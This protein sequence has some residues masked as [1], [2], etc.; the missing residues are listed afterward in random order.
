MN[1]DKPRRPQFG[2]ASLLH[3]TVVCSLFLFGARRDDPHMSLFVF[4]LIPIYCG[5]VAWRMR[6]NGLTVLICFTYGIGWLLLALASW[7]LDYI[8]WQD[9]RLD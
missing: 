3:A 4:G 2:I 8:I 9:F 7:V 5:V 1:Q 6:R